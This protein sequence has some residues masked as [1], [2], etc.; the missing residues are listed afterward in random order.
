MRQRD[1][2]K[3]RSWRR[4]RGLCESLQLIAEALSANAP[5]L[6]Q[7]TEAPNTHWTN[8]PSAGYL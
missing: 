7:P 6:Y 4:L 5:E 3:E 8:C 1:P 2:A